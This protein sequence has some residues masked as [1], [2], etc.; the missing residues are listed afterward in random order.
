MTMVATVVVPRT[1]ESQQVADR[2]LTVA[3]ALTSLDGW[4]ITRGVALVRI[5][6]DGSWTATLRSL[7][8]PGALARAYFVEGIRELALRADGARPSRARVVKTE[9]TAAGER[10]CELS[11]LERFP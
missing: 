8:R 6:G 1:A 9:F 11:G 10:V 3:A 5:A 2:T 4:E 7:D